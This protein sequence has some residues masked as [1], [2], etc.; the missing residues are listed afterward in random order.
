MC[1]P[2]HAKTVSLGLLRGRN[3]SATSN[4]ASQ[5]KTCMNS[6]PVDSKQNSKSNPRS[7]TLRSKKPGLNSYPGNIRNKEKFMN[8]SQ[9][10]FQTEMNENWF[11]VS[12]K[13]CLNCLKLRLFPTSLCLQRS[14]E[15]SAELG[16]EALVQM[17]GTYVRNTEILQNDIFQCFNLDMLLYAYGIS[18]VFLTTFVG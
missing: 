6:C 18:T 13:V 15:W 5:P 8:S 14:R 4:G 1:D 7:R 17:E 16:T 10:T 9:S 3:G 11:S 2:H 12:A